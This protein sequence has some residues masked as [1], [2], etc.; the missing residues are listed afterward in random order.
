MQFDPDHRYR[1]A[2]DPRTKKGELLWPS[3]ITLQDIA[4]R[5]RLMEIA[6]D[7]N[8]VAAQYD[9]DPLSKSGTLFENVRGALIR[10]EDLPEKIIHGMA[11]RGWDRANSLDGDP[12]AG[13]LMVEYEGIKYILNRVKFQK[14]DTERDNIIERVSK[15]DKSR[16]DNSRVANEVNPGP[17][18]KPAHNQLAK[19]LKSHGIICMSQPATKDKRTRAIPFAA[20]VKYGEVRILDGQD[21]T[22]DFVAELMQFPTG[23]HDDQVDAGAHAYNALEDWKAGKV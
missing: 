1:W 23:S 14:T 3:K 22:E 9:Q 5:K 18:G 11:M 16:F 19:R 2:K 12:T 13:V 15:S 4:S 6:A 7:Q 17:D 10:Y 20:A 21:W 8:I